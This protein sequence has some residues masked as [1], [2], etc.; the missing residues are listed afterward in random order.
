MDYRVTFRV[1]QAYLG[2]VFDLLK[3][4]RNVSL[5]KVEPIDKDVPASSAPPVSPSDHRVLMIKRKDIRRII[6]TIEGN[7]K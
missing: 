4:E 5:E 2:L 1:S 7:R 3:G 6:Q